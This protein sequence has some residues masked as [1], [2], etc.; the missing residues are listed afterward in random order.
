MQG[1]EPSPFGKELS[2]TESQL[3]ILLVFVSFCCNLATTF[4]CSVFL[5]NVA[6]IPTRSLLTFSPFISLFFLFF[7]FGSLTLPLPPSLTPTY[8]YMLRFV[9]E[10]EKVILIPHGLLY[11]GVVS[12]LVAFP[13]QAQRLYG[14]EVGHTAKYV[15]WSFAVCATCLSLSMQLFQRPFIKLLSH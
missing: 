7:A 5:N 12:F 14:G 4:L 3:F 9:I 10:L 2:R 1:I 11:V 6:V 13:F 8:R 15:C